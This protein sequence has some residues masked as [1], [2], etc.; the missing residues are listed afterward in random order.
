MTD[1]LAPEELAAIL[2]DGEESVFVTLVVLS[3]GRNWSQAT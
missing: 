3:A 1:E 2:G